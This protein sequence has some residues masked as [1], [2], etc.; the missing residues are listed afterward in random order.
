MNIHGRCHCGNL[1]FELL[2]PVDGAE[3]RARAC[4]CDF[5]T[6]HG[7]TWTSH[8]D[9]RLHVVAAG[10]EHVNV[11]RFGT[12]SADFHV[13]TMCGNTVFVSCEIEGRVYAVVNVNTFDDEARTRVRA[14][15]VE[16]EGEDLDGR[17]ARRQ[18]TWIPNVDYVI[19]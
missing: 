17:L 2:W 8:P 10:H 6:R 5:C 1:T 3:I 11:Y 9:A 13:C 4:G 16:F 14:A 15:P 7:A 12:R 19:R 18:R